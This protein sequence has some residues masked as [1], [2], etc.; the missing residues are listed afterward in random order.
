MPSKVRYGILP[1]SNKRQ[2]GSRAKCVD[3]FLYESAKY[4][5]ILF[6]DLRRDLSN[7]DG[8]FIFVVEEYGI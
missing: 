7:R 1:N 6:L 2:G 5:L 3:K 8:K 4:F